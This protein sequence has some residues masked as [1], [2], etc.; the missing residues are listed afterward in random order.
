MSYAFMECPNCGSPVVI[1]ESG[2][3]YCPVCEPQNYRGAIVLP[4]HRNACRHCLG[5]RE[6]DGATCVA[7]AGSGVDRPDEAMRE[8]WA[9]RWGYRDWARAGSLKLTADDSP[10]ARGTFADR[11]WRAGWLRAE[12][13]DIAESHAE[14][15]AAEQ[16]HA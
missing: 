13:D 5:H 14:K 9:Y 6:R 12:R 15:I 2:L 7:C 3:I 10:F 1:T 16:L 4:F 11:C 8:S